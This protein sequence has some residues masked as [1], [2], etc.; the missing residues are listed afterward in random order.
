MSIH[1]VYPDAIARDAALSRALRHDGMERFRAVPRTVMINQWDDSLDW[2]IVDDTYP[3]QVARRHALLLTGHDMVI[4]RL[5]GEDV[6]AAER[7]LRDTVV[8]YLLQ[9]WPEY[10][11]RDG[12][13]VLSP[14]SGLGV[15]VGTGGADPLVA[16]ALLATEDLLLLLPEQGGEARRTYRLKSGA[17]LFPNGWSLRSRFNEP[18]PDRS[19]PA[20]LDAW[21]EKRQKSLRA[22]RLGRTP[23]DIHDGHVAHYMEKFADRVDRFFDAMPAGHRTWR[24]NWGMKMSGELFLHSDASVEETLTPTAE[25]WAAHGYLRSEHETFTKLPMT[26]AV[27][28]GIKTYLW[29]L[30][31]LVKNP[32]ALDALIVANDNLEPGMFAYRAALLPSF[33]EYLADVLATRDV[34]SAS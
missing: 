27:V 34:K 17:L 5:P 7:E 2:L 19:Q 23:C 28:F 8:D 15:D 32:I 30:S 24:R 25:N 21:R 13:L 33:R 3:A 26:G 29:K 12:S 22:A 11:R 16:V 10:F 31:E 4:D 1:G 14:L 9:A 20:A 18:E 6:H